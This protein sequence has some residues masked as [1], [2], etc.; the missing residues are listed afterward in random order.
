MIE[1][2]FVAFNREQDFVRSY[3]EQD[4]VASHPRHEKDT[5]IIVRIESS[6]SK[7]DDDDDDNVGL[8][9]LFN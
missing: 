2:Y 3:L 1:R 8:S 5:S 4:F 9:Q 6:E 7:G